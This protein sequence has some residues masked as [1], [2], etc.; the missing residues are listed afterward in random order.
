MVAKEVVKHTCLICALTVAFL[1]SGSIA[2]FC[3]TIHVSME[4]GAAIFSISFASISA[5]FYKLYQLV[6]PYF[7]G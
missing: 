4:M 2:I 5:G 6:I 3:E 1:V 7:F